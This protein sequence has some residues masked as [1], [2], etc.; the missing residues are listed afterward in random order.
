MK[1]KLYIVPI[2]RPRPENLEL[3]RDALTEVFPFEVDFLP[4]HFDL[5]ALFN[6]RRSQYHST[7]ILESLLHQMPDGTGRI[8]AVT[9]L[10]LYIPILTFVFGEAQL[11]GKAAVVSCHRLRNEFYG[12]PQ[13]NTLLMERLVKEAIHELGHTFGLVH[14]ENPTCVMHAS[15]YVEEID[16]KDYHFCPDCQGLLEKKR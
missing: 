5:D 8:L 1:Q 7:E 6:A 12:L 4:L 14:C 16:L 3:L 9:D 13:N 2:H 11:Q 10:D 15:T